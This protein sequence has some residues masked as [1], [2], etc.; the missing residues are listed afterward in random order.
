MMQKSMHTFSV[1]EVYLNILRILIFVH[2]MEIPAGYLVQVCQLDLESK[3]V[4]L[5]DDTRFDC[6]LVRALEELVMSRLYRQ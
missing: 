5:Q 4:F 6:K 1:Y 2:Y 3:G